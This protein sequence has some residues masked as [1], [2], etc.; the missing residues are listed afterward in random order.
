[1]DGFLPFGGSVPQ[2]YLRGGVMDVF[3][4]GDR[5]LIKGLIGF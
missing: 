4:V 3:F 1:M 2:F 5:L